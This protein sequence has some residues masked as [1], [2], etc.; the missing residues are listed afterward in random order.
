M[1]EN[2]KVFSVLGDSISTYEGY[3]P[4][5][6][7][8]FDRYNQYES[9]LT[10]V[11]DT[12]W[13]QVIRARDGLL[14]YNNSLAGSLVSGGVVSSHTDPGRIRDLGRN[15][16][17][18][19][20]LVFAGCN[21]WAFCVHPDVFRRDYGLMLDRIRETYPEAEIWCATLPEGR[22]V[23][24]MDQFFFNADGRISG[25]VYSNIIRRLAE[26]KG[27]NVA[28]LAAYGT[29]ETIDGVHP[30]RQGMKDLAAMWMKDL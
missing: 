30:N 16:I 6:G 28:D 12:W 24:P 2:K 3:T 27:V 15:G 25:E 11:E 26:E 7:V 14:G 1:K 29:Y 18:D 19:I 10:S 21:D 13:M 5:K 4:A 23:D 8:F 22:E 9:G 20:I 17:P